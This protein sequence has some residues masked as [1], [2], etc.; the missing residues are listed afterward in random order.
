MQE[1]SKKNNLPHPL[2]FLTLPPQDESV[3]KL[4]HMLANVCRFSKRIGEGGSICLSKQKDTTFL[5]N[6]L[7]IYHRYPANQKIQI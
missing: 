2:L 4:V 6:L 1:F 5:F 3:S 7:I